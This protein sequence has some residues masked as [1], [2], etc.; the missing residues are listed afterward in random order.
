[1]KNLWI[2]ATNVFK[3]LKNKLK[4]YDGSPIFNE[5][6]EIC[7]D[8]CDDGY[9]GQHIFYEELDGNISDRWSE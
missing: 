3:S 6:I 2:S 1:M 9:D 4:G 8:L 5:N 7:L